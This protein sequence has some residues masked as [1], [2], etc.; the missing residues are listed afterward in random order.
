VLN[1][2]KKLVGLLLC[3][4][5]IASTDLKVEAMDLN[6]NDKELEY[7][8][9][10]VQVDENGQFFVDNDGRRIDIEK[11]PSVDSQKEAYQYFKRMASLYELNELNLSDEEDELVSPLETNG[12]Q[13]VKKAKVGISGYIN[14]HV[15]Y[16]TSEDYNKG[17]ITDYGAY[18]TFTGFT[19]GFSWEEKHVNASIA[20]GGKDI[21]ASATGELVY[22]LFVNGD[23]MVEYARQEVS[24]SG[25]A[26]AVK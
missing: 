11:I 2:A 9:I 25:T 4:L 22:Y 3:V 5:I 1:K 19:G 23:G 17:T 12:D 13:I 24:L 16:T 18:T 6:F 14:L 26:F 7:G 21:N 8:T 10:E 20:P 15:Y